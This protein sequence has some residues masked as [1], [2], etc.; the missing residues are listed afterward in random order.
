M[1]G[2]IEMNTALIRSLGVEPSFYVACALTYLE[3]LSEREVSLFLRCMFY[4]PAYVYSLHRV[5]WPLLLTR[6]C[7]IYHCISI[8]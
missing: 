1:S 5:F 7:L 2:L 3:F 8:I 6:T 4:S